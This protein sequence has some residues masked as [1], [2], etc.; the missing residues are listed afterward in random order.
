MA[1]SSPPPRRLPGNAPCWFSRR[2]S[3][4]T[5][6]R[7]PGAGADPGIPGT[8]GAR[9]RRRRD[10]RRRSP[11]PGAHGPDLGDGYAGLLRSFR[12]AVPRSAAAAIRHP[13][14]ACVVAVDVW[15][16][17]R[18]LNGWRRRCGTRRTLAPPPAPNFTGISRVH[19]AVSRA[20]RSIVT[21]FPHQARSTGKPV[22]ACSRGRTP[23]WRGGRRR[24]A[25][26][27]G[28]PGGPP[29]PPA[30]GKPRG[31]EVRY[32]LDV[33]YEAALR[34]RQRF[35]SLEPVVCC[36]SDEVAQACRSA[37][38]PRRG[39][40]GTRGGRPARARFAIICSGTAALEAAVL[41]CPG[42]VTYHGSP[43]QRWEWRTFHVDAL[44]AA[45]G[46]RRSPPLLAPDP[47]HLRRRGAYPE[48]LDAPAEAVAA[49]ALRSLSGDAVSLRA[50]LD[51]VTDLLY[52]EPAG[53]VVA[54]E[55]RNVLVEP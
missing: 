43:L 45:P 12:D 36:A 29:R 8:R 54:R 1:S 7:A 15:Q 48:L 35:P 51:R 4:V 40:A 26:A 25:A 19:G 11:A 24:A 50:A 10:G 47:Q 9:P 5:V 44:A 34:I 2:G 37:P 39:S 41:G 6:G 13:P 27:A 18:V 46:G 55:A 22:G 30:A 31:L 42:V 17:L 3:P 32:S 49:A 23:A 16:P 21:P 33:Q 28:G 53:E 52:W 20:F 38:A 14:P